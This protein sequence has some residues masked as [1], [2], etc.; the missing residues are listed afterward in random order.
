MAQDQGKSARDLGFDRRLQMRFRRF[1]RGLAKDD[2]ILCRLQAIAEGSV[3]RIDEAKLSFALVVVTPER[4]RTA[5]T[6]RQRQ[7]AILIGRGYG[8]R[9]IALRLGIATGTVL[10]IVRSI[11][12]R[13]GV[14]SRAAIARRAALLYGPEEPTEIGLP[15]PT[16]QTASLR[17]QRSSAQ[18]A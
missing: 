5:L 13:W 17:G 2:A 1:V 3:A 12:A 14:P 6:H 18:G 4:P 15:V 7:V 9:G 16:G 10:K 11:L 8:N